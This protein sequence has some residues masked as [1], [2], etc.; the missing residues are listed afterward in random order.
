M[1]AT[2]D[3]GTNIVCALEQLGWHNIRCFAHTLQPAVLKAVDLPDVSKALARCRNLVSHFN[4]SAKSTNLFKK[5]QTN[6]KHK[7]LCLIQEVATRWN[8]SY[9]MAERILSQQQ[10]ICATLIELRKGEMIPTDNEFKTLECFV[11][12]T[13]LFVDITEALGAEKWVTISTL[14]PLLHKILNIYLK[15]ASTDEKVVAA[16]KEAMYQDLSK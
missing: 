12:V 13:K 5:K 1:A 16:M 9:Y 4:R 3:N 15:V 2:T 14:I 11:K 6:L 7:S 10:P 8:S